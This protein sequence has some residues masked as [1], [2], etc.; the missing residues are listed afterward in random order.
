MP[1]GDSPE[2]AE[3]EGHAETENF[4]SLCHSTRYITVQPP[5]PAAAWEAEVT[6]MR[7]K[8]GAPISDV[9]AALI[10]KYLQAH[11]TPETRKQ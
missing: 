11:Y 10:I 5:P 4:C 9:S 2:L 3:G 8:F 1:S 6:N 7:K